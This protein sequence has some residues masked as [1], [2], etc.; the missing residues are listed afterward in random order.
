MKELFM[1]I[2]RIAV[3]VTV[4]VKE[5]FVIIERNARVVMVA[6]HRMVGCSGSM[7]SP[8]GWYNVG[9]MLGAI[10][11]SLPYLTMQTCGRLGH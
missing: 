4:A 6:I 8:H 7:K 5:L 11:T 1:I 3:L 9:Q 2:A 10:W